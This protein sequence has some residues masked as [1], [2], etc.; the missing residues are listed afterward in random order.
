MVS[1]GFYAI[2]K[3]RLPAPVKSRFS[4]ESCRNVIPRDQFESKTKTGHAY[5]Q[6]E[7]GHE[8]DAMNNSLE[9]EY[10]FIYAKKK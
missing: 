3:S 9:E 4:K 7:R 1:S 8:N 2:R 10:F 6:K 5:S